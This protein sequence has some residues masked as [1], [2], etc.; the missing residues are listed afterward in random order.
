MGNCFDRYLLP[1]PK[2]VRKWFLKLYQ[3]SNFHCQLTE[4]LFPS[5]PKRNLKILLN[6]KA[7][8]HH[9][10]FVHSHFRSQSR[11]V[12]SSQSPPFTLPSS[13]SPLFRAHSHL[14]SPAGPYHRLVT[15][16]DAGT[17]RIT[18]TTGH[19][20]KYLNKIIKAPFSIRS[21]SRLQTR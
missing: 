8:A 20:Q 2:I 7:N 11:K 13:Q 14:H 1:K 16:T 9:H 21:Q 12:R 4:T 15:I 19:N 10:K 17:P 3:C 6:T 5:E 18:I